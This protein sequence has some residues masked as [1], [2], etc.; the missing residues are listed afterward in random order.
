MPKEKFDRSKPHVNIG[1]IGKSEGL[2]TEIARE[3]IRNSC[4]RMSRLFQSPKEN[5][6]VSLKERIPIEAFEA[7]QIDAITPKGNYNIPPERPGRLVAKEG[8]ITSLPEGPGR[9]VYSDSM[10]ISHPDFNSGNWTDIETG[11]VV[12]IKEKEYQELSDE[13]KAQTLQAALEETSRR[14]RE[15]LGCTQEE[16]INAFTRIANACPTVEEAGERLGGAL[17]KLLEIDEEILLVG[18]KMEEKLLEAATPIREELLREHQECEG[19]S[20]I[21]SKM[22]KGKEKW[23]K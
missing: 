19:N 20:F 22:N 9:V 18:P 10:R 13:E 16:M 15:A 14:L 5:D 7:L 21:N 8:D 17:K 11:K 23:Q 3:M 12:E 1:T 6:E 2:Y 4:Q